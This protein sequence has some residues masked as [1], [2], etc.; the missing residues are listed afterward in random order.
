VFRNILRANISFPSD[1]DDHPLMDLIGQLLARKV[2]QR[3]G[4]RKGGA[5]EIKA[6][7][8][9]AGVPWPSLLKRT[10]PA[11]WIPPLNGECDTSHFDVSE[12]ATAGG[13]TSASSARYVADGSKW[14]AAF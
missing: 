13:D 4:C 14:D 8:W 3:I 11:P 1:L 9:L 12:D 7:P 6:H 10:L 5:A 2:V